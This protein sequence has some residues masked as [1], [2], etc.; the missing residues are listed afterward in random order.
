MPR[1][2]EVAILRVVVDEC[3][4]DGAEDSDR[5]PRVSHVVEYTADQFGGDAEVLEAGDDD[6]A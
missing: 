5:F 2:D 6:S 3:A 1:V 4:D